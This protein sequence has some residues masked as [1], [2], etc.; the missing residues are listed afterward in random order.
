MRYSEW[1]IDSGFGEFILLNLAWQVS[2]YILYIL[3]MRPCVLTCHDHWKG[4]K[5]KMFHPPRNPF[6]PLPAPFGD[7]LAPTVIVSR[8][9]KPMKANVHSNSYQIHSMRGYYG[10]VDTL[11]IAD[12]GRFDYESNIVRKYEL[13]CL[14]GKMM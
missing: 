1:F 4:Y 11:S 12:W 14:E 10:G 2:P 9:I 8:I 13:L 3:G 7:Q 6:G 5:Q